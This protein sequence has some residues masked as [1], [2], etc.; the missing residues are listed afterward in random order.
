MKR[1]TGYEVRLVR[2]RHS[3]R[4]DLFVIRNDRTR[5]TTVFS[6]NGT[7]LNGHDKNSDRYGHDFA[8][9]TGFFFGTATTDTMSFRT[10]GRY[11]EAC[12]QPRFDYTA[13]VTIT[14]Q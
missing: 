12:S 9:D 8:R 7:T 11:A 5:G 1:R 6:E 3:T 13:T 4:H 14:K 10:R 2:E